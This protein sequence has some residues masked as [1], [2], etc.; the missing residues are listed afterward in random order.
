MYVCTEGIYVDDLF[1]QYIMYICNVC[2]HVCNVSMCLVMISQDGDG[3][4]LSDYSS[5]MHPA[6]SI[7]I[8]LIALHTYIFIHT[9]IHTYV[10]IIACYNYYH[11]IRDRLFELYLQ[12]KDMQKFS[13]DFKVKILFLSYIHTNIHTYDTSKHVHIHK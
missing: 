6:R 8:T 9:Y 11:L 2:I 5:V 3:M 12:R 7:H 1:I 4:Y 10:F 13:Q